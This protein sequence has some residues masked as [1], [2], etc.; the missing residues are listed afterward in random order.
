MSDV[1]LGMFLSGGIDS[2]AITATM[3]S[4]VSKDPIRTFSV[5]FAEREANEFVY[6]R[7]VAEAYRTEHREV[8]VTPHQFFAQMP[9]LH[10][11]EDDPWRIPGALLCI[12][13]RS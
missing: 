11:H 2:A 4:L 3:A 12:S 10:W 5:A 1:P 13:C 9:R 6:A 8:L 7:L